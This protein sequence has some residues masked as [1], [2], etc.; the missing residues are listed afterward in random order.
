MSDQLGPERRIPGILSV[1]R[2][3]LT[4]TRLLR[5]R[6]KY[7]GVLKHG[8]RFR[9]G[10]GA[11]FASEGPIVFGDRVSI[12][13]GLHVETTLSVG[14]DVLISSNV[15]FI[16]NDHPF[17]DSDQVITSFARAGQSSTTVGS[18]CLIGYGATVLGNIRIGRGS[19]VGARAV[20][21]RDIPENSVVVGSPARIIRKRR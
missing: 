19:V 3:P 20:V 14:D 10:G 15:A 1:L 12:A 8:S 13:R 16:G 21:T 6:L 5:I 7:R 18:D 11:V 17:D 4:A 9:I 2:A